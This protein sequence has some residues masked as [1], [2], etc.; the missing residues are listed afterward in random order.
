MALLRPLTLL[1][2]NSRIKF[3]AL[4]IPGIHNI[5]CDKLSRQQA[6]PAL[7]RQYGMD[8][9]PTPLP[10]HLLPSN[11]Q[12]RLMGSFTPATPPKHS[13]ATTMPGFASRSSAAVRDSPKP[14]LPN[15]ITSPCLPRSSA[16][17]D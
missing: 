5:L 9:H 10:D 14:S 8:P 17:K 4:H 16:S 2:M 1:F 12:E 11:W 6:S 15:R 7:L 3:N 13:A